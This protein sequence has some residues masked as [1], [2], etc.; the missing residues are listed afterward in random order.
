MYEK[1][2]DENLI[3]SSY[4]FVFSFFVGIINYNNFIQ[5]GEYIN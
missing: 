1:I 4:F 3:S 5:I 2:K